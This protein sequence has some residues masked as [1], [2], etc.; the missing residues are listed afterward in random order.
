MAVTAAPR[1]IELPCLSPFGYDMLDERAKPLHDAPLLT[2]F[3]AHP[4]VA[5]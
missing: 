2:E 5:E 4:L 1:W 3:Q